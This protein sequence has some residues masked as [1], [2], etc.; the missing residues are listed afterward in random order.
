ML[1]VVVPAQKVFDEDTSTFYDIPETTLHLEHSLL[2]VSKWESIWQIPFLD[3]KKQKTPE[4]VLSYVQ[5]MCLDEVNPMVIKALTRKNVEQ[6][7]DYLSNKMTATWISESAK[8]GAKKGSGKVITSELLYYYMS[9]LQIPFT[10]E[11]WNLQRLIMLI[12][13]ASLEQQPAKKMPKNEIISQRNA[14]NK[15]RQAKM[16]HH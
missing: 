3:N 9:A 7:N 5:C 10:C 11:T 14:L 6:I 12:E 16:R 1:T 4:Q 2:A 13:V 15:A 8:N